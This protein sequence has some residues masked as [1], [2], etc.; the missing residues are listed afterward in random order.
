MTNTAQAILVGDK[1]NTTGIVYQT[2]GSVNFQP[3]APSA[4]GIL[5]GSVGGAY[6]E[7]H[8]DGGTLITPR[9]TTTS[10]S[11]GN[12]YL[13]S[14]TLVAS[15]NT[16]ASAFLNG[17]TTYVSAGGANLDDGGF[18]ITINQPLLD[19]S[20]GG[21]LT[22]LNTGT[23]TLTGT[24]T[25]TGDTL[26]KAGTLALSANGSISSSLNLTINPGAALDVSGTT[27]TYAL[28]S[29]TLHSGDGA[30]GAGT[31]VGN[32]NLAVGSLALNY[33]NGTPSLNVNG[34]TI[35]FSGNA[36][37]VTVF[38]APLAVGNYLL[39][40]TNTAGTLPSTVTVNGAGT[41][42]GTTNLLQIVNTELILTVNS[43]VTIPT[44]PT[45]ITF[46][47]SGGNLNLSWPSN[48]LGWS[49]QTQTNILSTN[50]ITI[51]GCES[52]TATNFPLGATNRAKFYRMHYQP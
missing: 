23:L 32:L 30:G 24:N 18:A 22:K 40:P 10:G 37:T 52:I 51:P 41:A 42:A 3:A 47:V 36:V 2:G 25:Y 43:A 14:G 29:Q 28:G 50:W 27:S 17:T 20:G 34:G 21:R 33:T 8:L 9:V 7:Y 11:T 39:I 13:N 46:S 5:F 45:N 12:L 4:S 16:F 15:A 26:V 38:G 6:G 35:N 1:T 44:T 49:L 31:L 19:G 48:Y